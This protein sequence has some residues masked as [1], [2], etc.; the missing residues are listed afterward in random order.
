MKNEDIGTLL[1][2]EENPGPLK[3]QRLWNIICL[4]I[5]FSIIFS[6]SWWL[7]LQEDGLNNQTIGLLTCFPGTLIALLIAEFFSR[8]M[9][10]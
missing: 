6:F 10:K 7:S 1:N 5:G 3:N 9:D 8:L 4:I 2:R